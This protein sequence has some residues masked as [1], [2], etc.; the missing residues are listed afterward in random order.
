MTERLPKKPVICFT[1]NTL[2]IRVP[3]NIL[4]EERRVY[5]ID[6]AYVFE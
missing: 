4:S 1:V 2:I 3:E 6:K 5:R